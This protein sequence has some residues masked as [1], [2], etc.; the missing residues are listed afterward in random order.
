MEEKS[1]CQS[2]AVKPKIAAL[3]QFKKFSSLTFGQVAQFIQ[4]LPKDAIACVGSFV[5]LLEHKTTIQGVCPQVM[6]HDKSLI[7]NDSQGIYSFDPRGKLTDYILHPLYDYNNKLHYDETGQRFVT[8]TD[9]SN[10]LLVDNKASTIQRSS[11]PVAWCMF[12]PANNKEILYK[13]CGS[14][15]IRVLNISNGTVRDI[16]TMHNFLNLK[17]LLSPDK[18]HLLLY[19]TQTPEIWNLETK[20]GPILIER[21]KPTVIDTIRYNH[22]GSIIAVC[23]FQRPL[24]IYNS[25]TGAKIFSQDNGDVDADPIQGTNSFV[26][27]R[28]GDRGGSYHILNLDDVKTEESKVSH[29][30]PLKV[31]VFHGEVAVSPNGKIIATI[32]NQRNTL[33]FYDTLTGAERAQLPVNYGHHTHNLRFLSD[34][35]LVVEN[36]AHGTSHIIKEFSVQSIL[37]RQEAAQEQKAMA[38][39]AKVSNAQLPVVAKKMKKSERVH[40]AEE[41][42]QSLFLT[43]GLHSVLNEKDRKTLEADSAALTTYSHDLSGNEL[44]LISNDQAHAIKLRFGHLI[45]KAKVYRAITDS[46]VRRSSAGPD[47]LD[48]VRTYDEK[49][50]NNP[51]LIEKAASLDFRLQR[52]L[53]DT[54]EAPTSPPHKIIVDSLIHLRTTV[55]DQARLDSLAETVNAFE[56]N[57]TAIEDSMVG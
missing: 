25:A 14:D 53:S 44:P 46:I 33:Y 28:L 45:L 39:E 18:K 50:P 22:D 30:Q 8:R 41:M 16:I 13:P 10:F 38:I 9:E 17:S 36:T 29:W 20:T 52:L 32:N 40:L 15:T 47:V 42:R 37:D 55:Y 51:L 43:H 56:T 1:S 48:L 3:L 2:P 12:N 57:S 27:Y 7:A 54:K 35:T 49:Y 11:M 31:P 19:G 34:N 5:P 4:G 21:D 23:G 24:T 6:T 26:T